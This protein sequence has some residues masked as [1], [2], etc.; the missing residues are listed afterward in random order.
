MDQ[1]EEEY[2]KN[3]EDGV[4]RR[5][6]DG[7]RTSEGLLMKRMEGEGGSNRDIEKAE[8]PGGYDE[9]EVVI[10]ESANDEMDEGD[11]DRAEGID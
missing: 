11:K 10:D 5:A 4:L 8:D 1:R 7:G 9:G 3:L 2:L 6:G